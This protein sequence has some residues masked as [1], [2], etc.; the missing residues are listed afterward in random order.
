MIKGFS[1]WQVSVFNEID[2]PDR[3][4]TNPLLRYRI[5][6]AQMMLE[7][8]SDA[9]GTAQAYLARNLTRM[10]QFESEA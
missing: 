8:L 4:A 7:E 6:E 3:H 1:N 10:D 2:K 5:I 9:V